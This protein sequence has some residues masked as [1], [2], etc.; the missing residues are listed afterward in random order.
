MLL[1]IGRLVLPAFVDGG[2][3]GNFIDAGLVKGFALPCLPLAQLT[4]VRVSNDQLLDCAFYVP[5][6]VSLAALNFCLTMWVVDT[7]LPL[8]LGDPFL[9]YFHP[10]A[11]W[12]DGLFTFCRGPRT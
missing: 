6:Q 11:P 9:R 12:A 5:V 4:Q 7:A 8:I 10:R 2:A 1:H 3:S